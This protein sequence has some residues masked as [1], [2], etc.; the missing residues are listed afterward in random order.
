MEPASE[1]ENMLVRETARRT[2][3]GSVLVPW[4][5]E[6]AKTTATAEAA[7]PTKAKAKEISEGCYAMLH[8]KSLPHIEQPNNKKECT[9]FI[10][11]TV[12]DKA[13]LSKPTNG[14]SATT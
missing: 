10:Q 13:N 14:S 9:F 12:A 8:T 1:W 11:H 4:E 2:R 7:V 3:L 5:K 6:S